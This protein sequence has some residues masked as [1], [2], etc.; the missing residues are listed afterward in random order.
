MLWYCKLNAS[1]SSRELWRSLKRIGVTKVSGIFGGNSVDPDILH[2]HFL[3][4]QTIVQPPFCVDYCA[5]DPDDGLCLRNVNLAD[6]QGVNLK[7]KIQRD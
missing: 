3:D 4:S 5:R 2:S 1:G 6:V 7:N